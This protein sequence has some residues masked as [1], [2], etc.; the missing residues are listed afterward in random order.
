MGLAVALGA[1]PGFGAASGTLT[2]SLSPASTVMAPGDS[3][4]VT[5]RNRD[6]KKSTTV[7]VATL[8]NPGAFQKVDGCTGVALGPGKVLDN[9]E[10]AP[11]RVK[12]GDLVIFSEYGGTEIKIDGQDY[13]IMKESDIMGVI[14][15]AVAG[16]KAA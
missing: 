13:L 10:R 2:F 14:E 5:V 3:V 12:E 6:A 16:K 8:T 11:M 9:G 7:L 15:G 1:T 4:T